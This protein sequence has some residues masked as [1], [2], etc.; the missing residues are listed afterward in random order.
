MRSREQFNIPN[1]PSYRCFEFSRIPERYTRQNV[2]QLR[3]LGSL[4]G[5][6]TLTEVKIGSQPEKVILDTAKDY[7]VDLIILGTD[8]SVGSDRLY[9]G[10]RVER[11]LKNASCPVIVVNK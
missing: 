2:E 4:S 1:W 5:V 7:Q 8:I 10:P 11:I 3:H 9:L 6:T